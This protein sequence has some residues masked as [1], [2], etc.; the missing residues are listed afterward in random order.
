M[1]QRH[2]RIVYM[3]EIKKSNLFL[4]VS[5]FEIPV[6]Y[7]L[8]LNIKKNQEWRMKVFCFE[9]FFPTSIWRSISVLFYY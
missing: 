9:V 6:Y 1:S 3:E 2:Q 5:E 7:T 4:S 8:I